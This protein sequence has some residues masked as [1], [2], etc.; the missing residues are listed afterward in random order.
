MAKK[1]RKSKGRVA[2]AGKT[3]RTKTRGTPSQVHAE[4]HIDGCDFEF[5]DSDAT[6][7][8]EL[9][10]ARGGVAPFG[11]ARRGSRLRT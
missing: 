5:V 10:P 11:R 2:R 8:A 9:P 3:E 7:D 1:A 4:D 6:P